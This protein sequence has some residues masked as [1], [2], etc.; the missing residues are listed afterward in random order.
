MNLGARMRHGHGSQEND[1]L[2]IRQSRVGDAEVSAKFRRLESDD[3]AF[4]SCHRCKAPIALEAAA[5]L[6]AV[7][8]RADQA[9][10]M[11]KGTSNMR[12]GTW[13]II[14][15]LGALPQSGCTHEV[16]QAEAPA[17]AHGSAGGPSGDVPASLGHV[18]ST[19]VRLLILG[20]RLTASR[21]RAGARVGIVNG[22]SGTIIDARGYIVTAAHIATSVDLQARATTLDGRAHEAVILRVSPERELALLKIEPFPGLVAVQLAEEDAVRWGD[23]VFAIGTPDNVAGVVASGEV[24]RPRLPDR[25]QYGA[26]GFSDAIEL[27]IDASPGFSG[28]PVFDRKGEMV[29]MMAGFGLGDTSRMPYKSPHLG[30][31]VPASAIRTYLAE[32]ISA[33]EDPD[34]R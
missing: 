15:L 1:P 7:R 20:D 23:R 30:Y 33:A 13:C 19:Y 31:A 11:R 9:A 18:Q 26:Y 22:A 21:G 8:R 16:S 34:E 2:H 17:L 12:A 5:T 28:G 4:A 14:A 25:V 3:N 29:G 6:K 24:R 32:A 10:A 27:D